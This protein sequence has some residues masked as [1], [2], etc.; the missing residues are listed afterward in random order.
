MRAHE[1]GLLGLLVGDGRPLLNAVG[2]GLVL[3]GGFAIFIAVRGELLPHDVAF[4][5]MTPAALCEL[6]QC[7]IV[8]FMEHDRVS[9]GGALIAIGVTYL[10]L[11]AGPLTAGQRWAWDLLAVSGIAGFLSFLAYIGYGY[12]DT[13][14]GT[15]TLALAVAFG[16]GLV[17]TRQRIA[18]QDATRLWTRPREL[19]PRVPLLATAFG[20][21][22]AGGTILVVGMTAVFVPED[23]EF[24]GIS[25]EQIDAANPRLIPLIAHDRAGFGGAICCCAI[26]LGGTAWKVQWD[27][28]AQQALAIAGLVGFSTAIG[29]HP[30]IGYT[31]SFHLAPAM[32]GAIAYAY[33]WWSMRSLTGQSS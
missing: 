14:H 6:N 25:R 10:W 29:V 19:R 3:A 26:L 20:M 21:L 18:W 11:V 1:R 8:H 13:W 23:L 30:A 22:S 4:L 16:S 7:R 2:F 27:R 12:L 9:F 17:L 24:M 15:A 33:G 28:A 32:L 5:S 31:D